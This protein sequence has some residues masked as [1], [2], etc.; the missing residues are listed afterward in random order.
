MPDRNFGHRHK[1]GSCV[2]RA[3]ISRA[4]A[5]IAALGAALV[6]LPA[7][8]ALASHGQVALFEDDV[9]LAQN[10]GQALDQMRAL[11]VQMVRVAVRWSQFAPSPLSRQTPSFD[12]ADP[13]AYPPAAWL[14]LDAIDRDAARDGIELMLVPTGYAPLWA[15]GR[16]ARRIGAHNDNPYEA[17]KPS[18][19]DYGQF[20]RALGTRYS[21]SFV[22]PGSTTA[23]PRV[24]TWELYNEPNFGEDLA[25][26]AIDRS[27]VLWAPVMYRG[28]LN[29]GWSALHSTGHGS[30]TILIGSLA[31]HGQQ[32]ISTRKYKQGLP[33]D[34]GETK[35]LQFLRD[36]YCL[37]PSYRPYRGV[38]A[39]V[40]HC[41]R[42]A[43]GSR[44][45]VAHN[46]A[47]FEASGFSEH[48]YPTNNPPD[49]PATHDPDEIDLSEIPVL[50]RVLDRIQRIYHSHKRFVIWNTEYG[51]VTDPPNRGAPADNPRTAHYVSPATAAYY[52]NWAEYIS[53][54]NPRIASTMQYLLY[55]P[56]PT[57]A[58][59]EYGGF[60]SGLIFYRTVLGGVAK[61]AFNAYR[62][63]LFLPRTSARHG[64]RLEV[65]GAV[66]PAEYAALDTGLPQSAQIQFARGSSTSFQ[67]LQTVPI[68]N[69][70]G[71]F[72]VR[73]AF[74][75]SGSV[76]IAYQ[77]ADP[78]I[79]GVAPIGYVEPL[80]S[81]YS[82]TVSVTIK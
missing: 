77:V 41:P 79:S 27:R 57:V 16:G 22:P 13:N 21:G 12:A 11:G 50:C 46:P 20:V 1:L 31:A 62:M 61:P 75:A 29:A 5:A 34:Y 38:A 9:A 30:D 67:T 48:P 33:G 81:T 55:D 44:R 28:L 76:R 45:F 18:D 64:R 15:Q 25:P 8:A 54:R 24:S 59:P 47:L 2:H 58:T 65:W 17:F 51:Y 53:W 71:Y 78:A 69:P 37:D 4:T 35:P 56:N 3:A 60:A 52:L 70:Q 40:R 66:R 36:L 14:G 10:P 42:T 7:P 68:E 39:A 32:S 23:L 74:P 43:A 63:P 49:K 80:S 6:C 82:R 26:Q 73:I 72:D 19:S